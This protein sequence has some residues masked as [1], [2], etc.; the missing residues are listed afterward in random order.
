MIPCAPCAGGAVFFRDHPSMTPQE[1]IKKWKPVALTERATAQEHFVDLCR[2]FDHP[3]PSEDD[4]TAIISH[5]RRAATKTGGGKGC[6][7]VWKKGYFAWEYKRKNG[8]RQALSSSSGMRRHWKIRRCRSYATSPLR[9]S[10]R[11]DEHGPGKKRIR[12]D[13]LADPDVG[14]LRNVFYDPEKLSA[15]RTRA[16]VTKRRRPTN[17]GSFRS[18]SRVAAQPEEVAHFVNQLVFCFFANSVKLLPEGCFRSAS[19]L[20]S[21]RSKHYFE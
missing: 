14:I 1:F 7:D 20:A 12:L 4:P 8:S 17:S 3:T 10:H 13:E 11:L 18:R 21:A 5:S 15:R 16:A 6:A 2:L 19:D 9:I